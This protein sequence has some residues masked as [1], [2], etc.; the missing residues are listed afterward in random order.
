MYI[1]MMAYFQTDIHLE[2]TVLSQTEAYAFYCVRKCRKQFPVGK[3]HSLLHAKT[4][5]TQ[6]QDVYISDNSEITN[7]SK[8]FLS[9][10]PLHSPPLLI[11]SDSQNSACKCFGS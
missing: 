4:H 3:L 8:V 6:Y 11:V 9:H 7:T 10:T 1:D 5:G 2:I